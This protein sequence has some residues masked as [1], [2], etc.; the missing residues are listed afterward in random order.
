MGFV[1]SA[2]GLN[3]VFPTLLSMPQELEHRIFHE[4]L[5]ETAHYT[6][7]KVSKAASHM[8]LKLVT[9]EVEESA[10]SFPLTSERLAR[11]PKVQGGW[12]EAL[13]KRVLPCSVD[14]VAGVN[15]KYGKMANVKKRKMSQQFIRFL[16]AHKRE[17]KGN[18]PTVESLSLMGQDK[19]SIHG[20]FKTEWLSPLTSLKEVTLVDRFV[21]K[22]PLSKKLATLKSLF[23]LLTHA[24]YQD[25]L[26]HPLIAVEFYPP[27]PLFHEVAGEK[28][29]V[30]RDEFQ[31]KGIRKLSLKFGY[32]IDPQ[33]EAEE[34]V[35]TLKKASDLEELSF[36][37]AFSDAS[38]FAQVL[39]AAALTFERVHSL[40]LR[41]ASTIYL[42]AAE[43]FSLCAHSLNALTLEA[44]PGRE[45]TELYEAMVSRN[46]FFP[47][48]TSLCFHQFAN[49]KILLEFLRRAPDL[50]EL[51]LRANRD[52]AL[53][54]SLQLEWSAVYS[55]MI[56]YKFSLPELR[57]LDVR[58]ADPSLSALVEIFKCTPN[59]EKLYLSSLPLDMQGQLFNLF[60]TSHALLPNLK[61]IYVDRSDEESTA[62]TLKELY[63][64]FSKVEIRDARPPYEILP[65]PS[66]QC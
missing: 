26:G 40:D 61:I 60:Q 42:V 43:L 35:E 4:M 46:L 58:E 7:L 64:C 47:R 52:E 11:Y 48:L 37:D 29:Q 62:L 27:M 22:G 12:P 5:G 14:L 53:Y 59:L 23:P 50:K 15:E 65:C 1:S 28:D 44:Y 3:R 17:G 21:N 16:K 54:S 20:G 25:S 30:E 39:A 24:T 19:W 9:E 66:I 6:M 45:W 33:K 18:I 32:Q 63:R 34:L 55:E 57:V 13:C 2:G 38:Q 41:G 36:E 31:G 51:T 8:T 56:A 49:A 10:L